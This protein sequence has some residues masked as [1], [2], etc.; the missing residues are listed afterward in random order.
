MR[1]PTAFLTGWLA[2]HTIFGA[3]AAGNS[4]STLPLFRVLDLNRNETARIVLSDG[5]KIRVKLLE[6]TETRDPIRTAVRLAR[7][8]VEIDGRKLILDSGNYRLPIQ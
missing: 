6:V 8:T 2:L 7:V 4:S 1:F 5:K 3:L